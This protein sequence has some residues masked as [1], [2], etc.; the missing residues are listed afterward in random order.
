MPKSIPLW[1]RALLAVCLAFFLPAIASAGQ[2]EQAERD[3]LSALGRLYG[4]VR[5]F[6]PADEVQGVDWGRAMVQ[7]VRAVRNAED[8]E[9]LAASLKAVFGP[10]APS[11][12]ITA[13]PLPPRTNELEGTHAYWEHRG[14]AYGPGSNMYRSQ[15]VGLDGDA[16][17]GISIKPGESIDLEL[18]A[19][20]RA[21]V[22]MSLAIEGGET[23]PRPDATELDAW[24]ETI[25]NVDIEND[26]D[27]DVRAASVL[28]AWA[29]PQHF[30]PY[31]D[32]VDVDWDARLDAFLAA[33]LEEQTPRAFFRTLSAMMAELEDG[34]AYL[35]S[36]LKDTPTAPAARFDIARDDSVIVTRSWNNSA[37]EHGD[38]IVSVDGRSAAD[39]LARW[40]RVTAGSAHLRRH[41]ALN[42]FGTSDEG[43][44]ATFIIRRM[45][46][47][48]ERKMELT[49]ERSER[50]VWSF[51]DPEFQHPPV[52]EVAEGIWLVNLRDVTKAAWDEHLDEIKDARGLIV[53]FRWGG[54]G[55][56]EINSLSLLSHFIDDAVSTTT[57]ELPGI[58]RP[59]FD[60]NDVE[61]V[62]STWSVEP[63]EPRLKAEVVFMTSPAVVSF[64]ETVMAFWDH[65]GLA[66]IVGEPT[67]GCN[68]NVNRIG[69]LPS[70]IT[71]NFTGLR[72]RKHD[73]SV[74]YGVGYEPEVPISRTVAEIRS[75][76]DVALQRA[77]ELVEGG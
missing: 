36:E 61:W 19:G 25:A 53:D 17:L 9:A 38:V 49:V 23:Q 34:H 21:R 42:Q 27:A 37:L 16:T 58:V 30:F 75:G 10:I 46:G 66:R 12:V 39:E 77:I 40:E 8:P 33:A 50:S 43:N 20:V 64:G 1:M 59:G 52:S 31:F 7:G 65:Y 6:H 5:F 41:R 62:T 32:V 74:L 3:R 76:E 2:A 22:P 4:H 29:V 47:E 54:S 24:N 14:V 48:A 71:A 26:F 15:R 51:V 28:M 63:A 45:E 69:D 55:D 60:F 35:W 70:K 68:G 13:G 44:D 18:G 73:G 67:A 11:I 72:V 57:W 56:R